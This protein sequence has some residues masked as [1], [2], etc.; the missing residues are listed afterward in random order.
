MRAGKLRRRGRKPSPQL[1]SVAD[2]DLVR[3]TIDFRQLR[4]EIDLS[5]LRDSSVR[6]L[7]LAHLT[8]AAGDGIVFAAL[9]FAIL[10]ADGTDG[11]F[12]VALA[13]Q[14]FTMVAFVLPSGVIGDR[15]NRRRVV[16]TADLLRFGAR[17]AF[18]LL[19]IAGE[20][21][22]WQLLLAQAAN[23]AGTA[24]FNTTM[25]GFVPE[26]ISGGKRLL[27]VNAMR[28]LALSLGITL[29]PLIGAFVFNGAGIAATFA[30]D[31]G[32][33]LVSALL[34]YR[35]PTPFREEEKKSK[36]ISLRALTKDV[37]EGWNAFRSI[38][39][40]WQEGVGFAVINTL[41]LAPYFVIGP[42]VARESFGGS[43]TWSQILVGLGIGQLIGALAVMP[44]EPKRPLLAATSIFAA[45]VFPLVALALSAPVGLLVVTAGIGGMAASMFDSIWETVKQTHTPPH[46]RARLGSFDHLGGLGPVPLGYLLGAVIIATMG[47]TAGLIAGALVL[48]S[49][50]AWIIGDTSV[51]DLESKDDRTVEDRD[52]AKESRLTPKVALVTAG[53]E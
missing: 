13:V 17:G 20:A 9:P 52:Q 53:T 28:V 10:A 38:R 4:E 37:A 32:T 48:V 45:W 36:T 34:I 33:F 27:K 14:A 46:L 6:R 39:W 2:S 7:A 1:A 3:R 44:W 42:H 15:F 21:T 12:A 22:F 40:Y 18:A 16:V 8:S 25:D 41:V 31:A 5:V 49:A 23:G 11:Q 24:L 43:W 51:R 35:L 29:G 50:T 47:A 19:L 26:V 30:V